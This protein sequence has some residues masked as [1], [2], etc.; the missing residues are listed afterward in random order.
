MLESKY[1]AIDPGETAGWASFKE[2]GDL[3]A[4][5]QFRWT[6][7]TTW[8]NEHI[9][10][11]LIEVICEQY[12]NYAW[13]QQKKWSDNKTSKMIG[14]IELLADLR[15]VPCILQGANVKEIGAMWGG[16]EIPAKR[17][18]GIDHQIVA[19]AHG[20]Y[21]LQSIGVRTIGQFMKVRNKDG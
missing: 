8:G 17:K 21:R 13:K 5:G 4:M 15:G 11:G 12:V 1:L 10:S 18:N 2:N 16:F 14:K 9:H 6:D 19:A 3:L 20:I 7:F